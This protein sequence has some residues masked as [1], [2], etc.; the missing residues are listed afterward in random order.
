MNGRPK[1]RPTNDIR[2][3]L[4]LIAEMIPPRARVLD[5]GCG[6]GELLEYLA[7]AKNVD[8]RGIELSQKGVNQC[9]ARGLSAVQGDADDDLKDYPS[10][11]FDFAILSQT[12]QA[13]WDP[14]GVLSNLVRIGRHA[15]VSFP[16][17]GY[18][19]VRVDLLLNGR[20]PRTRQLP[21]A[22]YTT[23]NIHLCTFT[24]FFELCHEVG[25]IVEEGLALDIEGGRKAFPAAG[26]RANILGAQGVFKL[27]RQT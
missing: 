5:V 11:A 22:W 15:I 21:D 14:K 26:W 10:D 18:W 1:P 3:D 7:R 13:T 17:F 6:D 2:V 8:G 19:R 23:P 16:N 20:M 25:V 24:D 9:V 12:L 4:G 27:R